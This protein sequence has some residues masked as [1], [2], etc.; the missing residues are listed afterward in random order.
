MLKSII[1]S[2]LVAATCHADN[3]SALS[4]LAAAEYYN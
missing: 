2:C 3:W 4:K 1:F